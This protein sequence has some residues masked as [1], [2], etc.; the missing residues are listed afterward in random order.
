MEPGRA[1]ACSS[2][3]GLGRLQG[4]ILHLKKCLL[5]SCHVLSGAA[6]GGVRRY[7]D[8]ATI[9]QRWQRLPAVPAET[10]H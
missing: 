6:N 10:A 1:G 7:G 2:T 9:W 4:T 3:S 8:V 5:S